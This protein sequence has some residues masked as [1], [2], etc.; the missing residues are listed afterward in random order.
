LEALRGAAALIVVL[1]HCMMGYLPQYSGY[2]PGHA[3]NRLQGSVFFIF[4]NGPAAVCLFFV[5][6]GYVL[7]R[8]Y[9]E[10]GDT[11]IL[12][13]GAVKRWPRLAGP[14]LVTT[15]IS[16]A[17]FFFHLYDFDKAGIKSGSLWLTEF[18]NGFAQ[19]HGPYA[20]IQS[21]HYWNMLLQGAFLTFFRGDWLFDSS[22][23]T[24]KP[25]LMGSLIAFGIAPVLL[26]ARKSS[27]WVVLWL[28][29]VAV[30]V[31]H[32][33]W[34]ILVA[35]PI[36]VA[37]AVLLPRH[38]VLRLWLAIPALLLAFYLLGYS[39]AVSGEYKI[40]GYLTAYGLPDVYPQ[41]AGAAVLIILIETL[42]SLRSVFSGKISAFLGDLSFP[43][44]LVHALIICSAGSFVYLRFGALPAIT[45]VFLVSILASLPLMRFN[46]WWIVQVNAV[47]GILLRPRRSLN[48][49]ELQPGSQLPSSA[50]IHN[51]VFAETPA[52]P[53]EPSKRSPSDARA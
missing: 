45:S 48:F 22:L 30:L 29:A 1:Y 21:I 13:K 51:Q 37:M 9:C 25:E 18:G 10:S 50:A 3:D 49:Q 38:Y 27:V 39:G 14:V 16:Y 4:V 53:M 17:L 34:P 46:H 52:D 5:L 23:W 41:I 36:G 28:V 15:F 2:I 11:R 12:L 31:L 32:F 42:P 26:E 24:M 20:T 6:S 19:V 40:F 8:R 33:A 47:T 44:Y 35:F 7:T 43:I